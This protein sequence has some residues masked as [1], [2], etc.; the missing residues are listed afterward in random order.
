MDPEPTIDRCAVDS[1]RSVWPRHDVRRDGGELRRLCSSCL[2]LEYR[3][4]YCCRCFLLLGPEPPAHFDSGDPILAPPAPI[5]VCRHCRE[6]VAHRYCLRSDDDVF[7]CPACVAGAGSHFSFPV[8][9]ARARRI[10]AVAGR[11]SLSLLQ[12]AAAA[13]RETADRLLA[14]AMVEKARAERA[15][16]LALAVDAGNIP[17]NLGVDVLAPPGNIPAPEENIPSE[18]SAASAA[19]MQIVV[20]MPPSGNI[21]AAETE[22]NAS[23]MDAAVV[24]PSEGGSQQQQL[25]NIDLNA[26]PPRSPTAADDAVVVDVEDDDD[27]DVVIIAVVEAPKPSRPPTPSTLDLFPDGNNK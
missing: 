25:M 3:S 4:L 16:A 19:N 7:C 5:A 13:S 21:P 14:V 17:E 10:M 15:L 20:Y 6:A 12:K 18:S 26:S 23:N 22:S 1:C 9:D 2:L 8:D 11:I 27:D 24:T